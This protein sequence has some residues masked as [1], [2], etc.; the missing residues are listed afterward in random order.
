[1]SQS[2][3]VSDSGLKARSG[4]PAAMVTTQLQASVRRLAEHRA[5]LSLLALG[6]ALRVVLA[7]V[8]FPQSGLW[9]DIRLFSDWSLVMA[10]HGPGGFYSNVEFADYPPG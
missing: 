6:L 10:D 2:T 3:D 4:R 8:V 5:L 1:M 9:S 7:F